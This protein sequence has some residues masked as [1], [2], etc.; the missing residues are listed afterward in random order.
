MSMNYYWVVFHHGA[1]LIWMQNVKCLLSYY[2]KLWICS[3]CILTDF[4]YFYGF[5]NKFNPIK[6]KKK[7]NIYF[8]PILM[9]FE[10]A[11]FFYRLNKDN[12]L[13]LKKELYGKRPSFPN[14]MFERYI[15]YHWEVKWHTIFQSNYENNNMDSAF[16]LYNNE[17]ISASLDFQ[18]Y[19][20]LR[21]GMKI[22][23]P[24]YHRF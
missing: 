13:L 19:S 7:L 12:E 11:H 22:H 6:K 14:C 18:L 21:P 20:S 1:F 16:F 23:L 5:W 3:V 15:I 9:H 8:H 4:L 2:G 17:G 10:N 24:I